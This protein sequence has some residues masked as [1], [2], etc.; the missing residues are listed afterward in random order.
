MIA[1]K[2]MLVTADLVVM[3][4]LELTGKNTETFQTSND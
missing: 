3:N 4:M 1:T 2:R